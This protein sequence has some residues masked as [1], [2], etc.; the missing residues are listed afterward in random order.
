[1]VSF[2]VDLLSIGGQVSILQ[3]PVTL[4]HEA[5]DGLLSL[6]HH[7][8]HVGVQKVDHQI[9]TENGDQGSEENSHGSVA[10]RDV[11]GA[12]LAVG[13]GFETL[14]DTLTAFRLCPKG[15]DVGCHHLLAEVILSS[16]VVHEKHAVVDWFEWFVFHVLSIGHRGDSAT[17]RGPVQ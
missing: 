10:I 11:E 1:M 8:N 12:P 14:T 5:F 2:V 4:L 3:C 17:R 7:L 9:G 6:F 15:G 16:G 13:S